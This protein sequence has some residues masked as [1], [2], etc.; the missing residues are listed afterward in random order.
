M[1]TKPRLVLDRLVLE[2]GRRSLSLEVL[3]GDRWA[4][5]GPAGSGKTRLFDVLTGEAKPA[6]GSVLIDGEVAVAGPVAGGRRLTP[7]RVARS[8][9]GKDDS[10]RI[11]QV[12]TALG[13]WDV[14]NEPLARLTSSQL[15]AT[16]MIS[17]LLSNAG[18]V[19]IDG[20]LDVLDP[21]VLESTM[22]ALRLEADRGTAFMIA[23]NQ[24]ELAER[25]GNLIVWRDS[26]A[27][28]AGTSRELVRNAKPVELLVETSD[29]TTVR[30]MV[31]P[32]CIEVRPTTGGLIITAPDGQAL[33]AR[34]LTH[35]YGSVKAVVVR[36]VSFL[37][38]LLAVY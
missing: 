20:Q 13:L 2:E 12:L 30:T 25:L 9:A 16:E 10:A 11:V 28:F 3:P 17:G 18:L 8:V 37:E 14:M 35:G 33:A 38:A 24:P 7:E 29:V 36:E 6:A 21:W 1:R 22:E 19:L 23:T 32:F 31:E 5:V 34:L 15:V 26:E 27:R 4:I